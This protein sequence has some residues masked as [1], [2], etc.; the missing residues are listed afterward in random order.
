MQRIF[1][2]ILFVSLFA[3]T[4]LAIELRLMTGSEDGTYYQIG[5]EMA[6]VTEGT[7]VQLQVLPSQGSWENIVALFNSDT[8]FAIFQVDAFMKAAK[9]LY[10]NA[11]VRINEE[12]RVV[13]PLYREEIHLIKAAG[14]ELDF[15]KQQ[16]FVVGCGLENSGSCLTAALIEEVYGKQFTYVH[17]GY[18]N[19]LANLKAGTID[20]VI[21]TVGKP[22][23]LLV[24]QSGLDLVSL[25]RLSK[26]AEFYSR[27]SFG[28]EDYPWLT[29]EVDTYAVRS[30]LATMIH[31][32]DGL[33]NDLVGSVHFSLR[34]NEDGLKKNGHPKW[35]DV[36]FDGYIEDLGH[37]GALRSL[38]VCSVIR[39]FGYNCTDI[40]T[41]Q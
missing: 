12:I 4:S 38:S 37:A 18:E 33:A 13:M 31:E 5:Q 35:K 15:S 34:V 40:M 22:F 17:D 23:P 2:S 7:G 24:E 14:K 21:I 32:E 9:N 30:V 10:Q 16:K 28:P 27:T 36:L 1:I 25:P 41:E 8:E 26:A 11:S 3:S 19:A 20:L 39:N 29:R 6:A